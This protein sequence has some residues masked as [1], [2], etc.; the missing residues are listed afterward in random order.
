MNASMRE[1]LRL[2]AFSFLWRGAKRDGGRRGRGTQKMGIMNSL[3]LNTMKDRLEEIRFYMH[4]RELWDMCWDDTEL[5]MRDLRGKEIS[6]Q[7]IR[8][9]GSVSANIEEGYGR[10]FGKEYPHYLRIARGS[11][12]ETKG[13]YYRSGKL[14]LPGT[15]NQRIAKLDGIIAAISKSIIT[16]NSK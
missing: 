5:L 9:M 6:K 16:L 2:G 12:R 15:V 8:S 7:L 11:A 13:W 14:L 4:S 1:S 3:K 10:G